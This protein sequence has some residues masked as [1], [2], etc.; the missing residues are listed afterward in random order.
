MHEKERKV[1]GGRKR[2]FLK[3]KLLRPMEPQTRKLEIRTYGAR[4]L[5]K[6]IRPNGY[7]SPGA[8][9][10]GLKKGGNETRPQL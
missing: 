8:M 2:A 1:E 9:A 7:E 3:S 5:K 6:R 10:V 4:K